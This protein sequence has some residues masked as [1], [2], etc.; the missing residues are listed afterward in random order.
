MSVEL[1]VSGLRPLSA[2]LNPFILERLELTYSPMP[3]RESDI[4]SNYKTLLV[5]S[6]S[7]KSSLTGIGG[8]ATG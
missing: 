4:P 6:I 2:D 8:N 7:A 5:Q 3:L 1:R